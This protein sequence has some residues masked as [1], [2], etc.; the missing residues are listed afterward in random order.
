MQYPNLTNCYQVLFFKTQSPIEPVSLVHKICTDAFESASTQKHRWVQRLTPVSKTSKATVKGLDEL[1]NAVL[2]PVFHQH[3]IPPKKV[4]IISF[5]HWLT[6][7]QAKRVEP[8]HAMNVA[9]MIA[10]V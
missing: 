9:D 3:D 8:P 5:D 10:S 1:S 6:P 2:A 7:M 4:F